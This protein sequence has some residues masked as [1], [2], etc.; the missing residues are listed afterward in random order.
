MFLKVKY[1]L[2]SL[3]LIFTFLCT[4]GCSMPQI[5]V[6]NDPLTPEE[7]LQLGLSYEKKGLLEEAI[8]QYKEASKTDARGYLFL[9]NLFL[10][11]GKY[12]EAEENYKEAIK[13]DNKLA[14]AY[15][16]LAWLYCIKGE[17]LEEAEGLVKKA[18]ELEKDNKDKLKIY[19][20]TLEK[21]NKIKTK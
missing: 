17:R 8:K 14:D 11:E 20:D 6:L 16:N 3:F 15:N 2:F 13:K 10:K 18:M 21:I 19:E 7:H 12:D 4:L 5:V 1:G 9:G